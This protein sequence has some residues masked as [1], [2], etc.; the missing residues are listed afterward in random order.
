[1]RFLRTCYYKLIRSTSS[2]DQIEH[3]TGFGLYDRSFVDVLRSL[4]DPAPFLRSVVA[5]Y[6]FQRGIVEYEQAER[7]AGKTHNNFSTLYD[8]AML[9]FT[10][11]TKFPIRWFTY[12]GIF[13]GLL[14]GAGLV[15]TGVLALCGVN[16]G[17]WALA[18]LVGVFG[19]INTVFIGIVGE[20]VLNMKGKI[21]RRPLV[22]EEKRFNLP[23]KK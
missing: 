13:L 11:Y 4:D 9:S 18:S 14:S 12:L 15:T 1:M 16:V 3:F 8:A 6:G 21:L 7:R 22:I 5:E 23:E 2:V 17:L 20:Y 19:S 10:S